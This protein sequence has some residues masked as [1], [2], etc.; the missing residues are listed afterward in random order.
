[1]PEPAAD[2]AAAAAAPSKSPPVFGDTPLSPAADRAQLSPD[3]RAGADKVELAAFHEREAAKAGYGHDGERAPRDKSGA[4]A[5]LKTADPALKVAEGQTLKVGDL[6]LSADDVKKIMSAKAEQDLR[7]TQVPKSATDYKAEL[8]A[9][10]KLPAEFKFKAADPM[11]VDAQNW[12]HR[13]GL[14]QDQYG[15]MLGLYATAHATETKQIAD[16][17]MK[18][19][20]AL[21][22]NVGQRVDAVIGWLR[23]TFGDE[24]A[25]PVALSLFTAKHVEVFEKIMTRLSSQGAASYSQQHRAGPDTA[26]SEAAWKAMSYSDKREYSR[27]AQRG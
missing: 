5:P 22:P 23:G 16:A 12:A 26:P 20:E 21:G 10:L 7:A 19:R 6:E 9:D 1:M 24:L 27:R 2:T 25:R 15:Q 4:E 3:Q 17:Q 11:L 8:P 14:T 13:N 18:Q